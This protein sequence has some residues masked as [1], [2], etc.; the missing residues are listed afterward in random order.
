M[1]AQDMLFKMCDKSYYFAAD[2][3]KKTEVLPSETPENNQNIDTAT[4]NSTESS[5]P[6]NAHK[7]DKP[8]LFAA[9]SSKRLG[10]SGETIPDNTQEI[11]KLH[12]FTADSSK[13]LEISRETISENNQ[14][15]EKPHVFAA[16]SSKKLEIAPFI[17]PEN[18]RKRRSIS[19]KEKLDILSMVDNGHKLAAVA[20]EFGISSSTA[21]TIVKERHKIK[22]LADHYNIDPD[23]KRM[24]LGIYRDVDEAVHMWF[25]QMRMKNIP[26]NGPMLQQK[27]REFAIQLGHQNFEGSSGWLFRFR[28]RHGLSVKTMRDND[29]SN[30]YNFSGVGMTDDEIVT[31]VCQNTFNPLQFLDSSKEKNSKSGKK[32]KVPNITVKEEI[33]ENYLVPEIE[34]N[35]YEPVVSLTDA[36]DLAEKLTSFLKRHDV[37]SDVLKSMTTVYNFINTDLR[38]QE[39]QK[40]I[41]DYFKP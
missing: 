10:T 41:T 8:F 26:I 13:K 23:R 34:L 24:R 38:E 25:R 1:D 19:V 28:E 3:S 4:D 17:M 37:S 7:I 31:S 21:S 14:V 5:P 16:D 15:V 12:V 2:S 6:E 36:V 33:P 30:L 20:R 9:D 32:N 40:K 11:D 22:L 35:D 29:E 27:A 39:K 18:I